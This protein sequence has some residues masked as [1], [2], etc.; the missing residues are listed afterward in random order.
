[1]SK[2]R[3]KYVLTTTFFFSVSMIGFYHS[4]GFEIT[5]LFGMV[6][7]SAG[8]ASIRYGGD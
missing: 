7:L 5:V 6:M 1:M 3:L 2:N 4:V 8:I